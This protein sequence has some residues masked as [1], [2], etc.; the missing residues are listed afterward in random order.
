MKDAF[1]IFGEW[2]ILEVVQTQLRKGRGREAGMKRP[3]PK[4]HRGNLE[5]GPPRKSGRQDPTSRACIRERARRGPN[6]AVEDMW[7]AGGQRPAGTKSDPYARGS[8]LTW[9]SSDFHQD[10][11]TPFRQ[12]LTRAAASYSQFVLSR[13]VPGVLLE[14]V[15]ERP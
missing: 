3:D 7:Y 8:V 11:Q 14:L 5:F 2:L 4:S 6:P 13:S 12:P 9:I 1:R 15:Q 10:Q